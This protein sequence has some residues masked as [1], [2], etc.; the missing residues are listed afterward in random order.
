MICREGCILR[1]ESF[2]LIIIVAFVASCVGGP[3][4]VDPNLNYISVRMVA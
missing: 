1:G 2:W 3:T 4:I